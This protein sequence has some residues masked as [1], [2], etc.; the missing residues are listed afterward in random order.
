[1]VF[2]F[3][4]NSAFNSFFPALPQRPPQRRARTPPA[5]CPRRACPIANAPSAPRRHRHPAGQ[6][7]RGGA[8]RQAKGTGRS[9]GAVGGAGAA[10][11]TWF[12]SPL[13]PCCSPSFSS[14]PPASADRPGQVGHG[15]ASF[16][17]FRWA[18]R[19]SQPGPRARGGRV[20][21]EP[22]GGATPRAAPEGRP[23]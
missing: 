17:P 6:P 11:W 5:G 1:M 15:R 3:S 19:C 12:C 22:P 16:T 18:R 21:P 14:S 4:F 2:N 9:K 10:G 13:L 7:S 20:P 23:P 8:L